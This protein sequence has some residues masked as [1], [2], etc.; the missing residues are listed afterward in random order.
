MS[1]QPDQVWAEAY[2]VLEPKWSNYWKDNDGHPILDG[3][4]VVKTTSK[5]PSLN[6]QGGVVLK[7]RF[8]VNSNVLLPLRPEAVIDVDFTNS[9]TIEVEA[10]DPREAEE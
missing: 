3:A 1:K 10:L 9:E 5:R 8:K 6:K 7:L 2:V 4:R